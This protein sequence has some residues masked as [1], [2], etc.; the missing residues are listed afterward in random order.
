M[1]NFD[2]YPPSRLNVPVSYFRNYHQAENPVTVNL[3]DIL[4]SK[5]H[6]QMVEELRLVDNKTTREAMKA[7]LP[8][9][10]PSGTFT[11]RADNGLLQHSGL[12]QIDIDL[13]QNEGVLN[14]D[15][16]KE[17]LVKLRNVAYCG[18]SVSG[19]GY[20]CLIPIAHPNRHREHFKALKR[21]FAEKNLIID[22][23]CINVSRLRGVSF[24]CA[25]YFNHEASLFSIFDEE[26]QAESYK[27]RNANVSPGTQH[28]KISAI[29]E[30]IQ[31]KGR[32]IASSY[33]DW[34]TSASSIAN[35]MGEK[36]REYFQRLSQFHPGYSRSKT[37]HQFDK[38]LKNRYNYL[39]ASLVYLAKQA[40]I[41]V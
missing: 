32:D 41:N 23:S 1:M 20:Y 21:I 31:S 36:G 33:Q 25:P 12:I 17:Q 2:K 11:H 13:K 6:Q 30:E 27:S 22:A 7:M 37:D 18:L 9:F 3:L 14:Y 5:R 8:A 4:Y 35:S 19:K 10:T 28:Q 29:L 40:G 15:R 34:F 38:V 24:D 16:L 39:T 26:H